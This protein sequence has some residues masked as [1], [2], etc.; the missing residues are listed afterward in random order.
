MVDLLCDCVKKWIDFKKIVKDVTLLKSQVVRRWSIDLLVSAG[1]KEELDKIENEKNMNRIVFSGIEI[2][3]LWAVDLNWAQ[4]LEKIKSAVADFIKIIEPDGTYDLGYVRHL[5][6]KLKAT[7]QILEVTM[8]S[9]AQAKAL[10]KAY[11]AKIKSWRENKNFPDDV[12]GTSMGPSLTL[13]T[14]VR[15]AIL[16]ALAKEIKA[17][18]EDTD[19][20]VIQHVA[21]PVLK[22]E[23]GENNDTK[24]LL[25]LGFAQ[26]VAY[27]KQELPYSNLSSQDLYDAYSIVGNRF[28][29]E[30][31]HYFVMLDPATAKNFAM[32]RKPRLNKKQFVPNRK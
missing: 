6:F 26:A 8:G 2:H 29:Q 4:R 5:N 28:G 19:A 16:H 13:A 12:K 31:N 14:R 15:I 17:T 18:K 25:T 9:E 10:R 23:I 7:R 32:K 30:L 1:T 11:G 21:R 27:Y 22:I 20:W 3:D 24:T